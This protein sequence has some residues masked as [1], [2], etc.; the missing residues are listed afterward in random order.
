MHKGY[1]IINQTI[2]KAKSKTKNTRPH[3]GVI[4]LKGL[5]AIG[6]AAAV[7]ENIIHQLF[8]E[9]DFTVYSI[10][11][12]TSEESGVNE[13]YRQVVFKSIRN[14]KLNT[15][16]YYIK[17]MFHA[18]FKGNYDLIHL[19]HRDAA[20]II[21]FLKIRYKVILT[22]HGLSTEGNPKWEKYKWF[23]DMQV[24]HFIKYATVKTCVSKNEQRILK[25]QYKIKS[26]YIPNGITINAEYR[27]I[28]QK[29]YIYFAAGRIM[30]S[31][32][33]HLLFDAMQSMNDNTP[34]I[35]SGLL[36]DEDSYAKRLKEHPIHKRVTY[37]GMVKDKT[38]LYGYLKNAKF[39]VFP[40]MNEAMSMM[41]LEAVSMGCPVI[42]SNIQANK[43]I[44]TDEEVL[45]FESDNTQDLATKLSFAIKN[46]LELQQM[47]KRA[48]DRAEKEYNWKII[49]N[50]YKKIYPKC[51]V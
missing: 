32:G 3:I 46:P 22:T 11:S 2:M 33:C 27:D 47:A 28:P 29:G 23:F 18:L 51:S 49:S 12:H 20:F 25:N 44:F 5:P 48:Y 38:L 31:K 37:T 8:N 17:A 14:K 24:K 9:Y 43:D 35:V 50:E 36:I 42:C 4:G 39:F 19:H 21:P 1:R 13:E 16:L 45:F 10:N 41:L 30:Y 40:S 15:L 34:I 6:G 26:E 7:G